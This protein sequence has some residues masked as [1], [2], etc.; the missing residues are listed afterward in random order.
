MKDPVS[1]MREY[2]LCE[3]EENALKS[4]DLYHVL[5]VLQRST[6][7]CN[8]DNNYNKNDEDNKFLKS[9]YTVAMVNA[10]VTTNFV[11]KQVYGMHCYR[12][13]DESSSDFGFDW[14]DYKV[15]E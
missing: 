11:T 3:E 12:A 6:S 4:A 2:N 8:N 1:V 13:S 7:S 15:I 5:S 14:V 9:E 10:H